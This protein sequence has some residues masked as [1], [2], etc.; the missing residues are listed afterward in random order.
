LSAAVAQPDALDTDVTVTNVICPESPLGNASA[1]VTGGTAPYAYQW[2]NDNP[3]NL[4]AGNYLVV[5]ID[6]NGC[7]DVTPFI[8]LATDDQAPTLECPDNIVLCGAD[9]VDYPTPS[10][11]D[12]C[13]LGSSALSLISGLPSGSPFDDGVSVQVFR[14][15]DANSNSATCSFSV[16][17]L[18]LPDVLLDAVADDVNGA[19]LGSISV[20]PTGGAGSYSF[21]WSKNGQFFSAAED[22]IGLTA[23]VYT[24]VV[25]DANGCTVVLASITLNNSVGSTEPAEIGRVRIL[26]NPA[27]NA[28]RLEIIDLDII[29]A[30]IMDVRGQLV[31][32]LTPAECT[33]EIS[34]GQLPAGIY[35]LKIQSMGGGVRALKFA[36]AN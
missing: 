31:Q 2:P 32:T 6:I 8:I 30:Q 4:T 12:N 25:T 10:V 5:V 11:V 16:T 13:Q 35:W 29:A 23:G 15:T 27:H 36:K 9:L 18:P 19:G 24:L 3:N 33:S 14:A 21:A 26:P 34:V 20:T 7:T 22:L 17:V 28:I 1:T